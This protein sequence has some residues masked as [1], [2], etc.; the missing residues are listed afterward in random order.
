LDQIANKMDLRPIENRFYDRDETP[1]KL[2]FHVDPF[3]LSRTSVLNSWYRLFRPDHGEGFD[4][5]QRISPS[6]QCP[7]IYVSWYDAWVFCLWLHWDGQSCRLPKEY[8]WEYAA[9]AGTD[10]SQH[11]WWGD[12]LDPT[13][14]TY[15]NPE[16]QTTPPN[17]QHEN[18]WGLCDMLGNVWEWCEDWYWRRYSEE[19]A[20][21][22]KDGLAKVL[23]GG[24][25][26]PVPRRPRSAIRDIGSLKGAENFR[27]FRIAR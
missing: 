23:R 17:Q 25:W 11:Y 16:E 9:K 21:T 12:K 4:D 15:M 18:P 13:K 1:A 24:S 6:D 3:F 14:C 2:S 7:V 20:T 27:G 26:D 8:E 5:Y 22:I 10:W 19:A